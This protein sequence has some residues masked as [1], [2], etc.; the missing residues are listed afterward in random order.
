M[1]Q[2][3]TIAPEKHDDCNRHLYIVDSD[4]TLFCAGCKVQPAPEQTYRET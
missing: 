3:T 2:T 1:T 4:R